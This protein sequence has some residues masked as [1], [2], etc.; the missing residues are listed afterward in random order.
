[1]ASKPLG[2]R[3]FTLPVSGTFRWVFN[4]EASACASFQLIRSSGTQDVS[5]RCWTTDVSPDDVPGLTGMVG[6]GRQQLTGSAY[7]KYW[8]LEPGASG[9]L[10]GSA[11]DAVTPIMMHFVDIGSRAVMVEVSSSFG[12]PFT[13]YGHAK[14]W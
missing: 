10:T 13:L 7:Q 9:S 6:D 8:Y 5:F 4:T 11:T 1:M 2:R 12:G 3:N 14:T